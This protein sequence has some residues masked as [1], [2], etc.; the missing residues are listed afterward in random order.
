[1]KVVVVTTALLEEVRDA[2]RRPVRCVECSA[3]AVTGDVLVMF[4]QGLQSG[5]YV[6]RDLYVHRS[7]FDELLADAPQPV[8]VV[9]AQ[10]A[11]ILAEADRTGMSA[12]EA[13]LSAA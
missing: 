6:G 12:V 2:G 5:S 8:D 3:R 11:A 1:M 9:E 13:L 4:S 7:H 10:V